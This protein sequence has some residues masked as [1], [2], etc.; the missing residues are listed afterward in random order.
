MQNCTLCQ[1]S[2]LSKRSLK[3]GALPALLS[4]LVVE[5]IKTSR[6]E[7]MLT[8]AKMIVVVAILGNVEVVMVVNKLYG[9]VSLMF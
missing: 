5:P 2:N 7:P 3:P 9:R 4:V 6:L 8:K 1:R